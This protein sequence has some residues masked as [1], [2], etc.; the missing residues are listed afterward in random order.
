METD[1]DSQ[2]F[3]KSAGPTAGPTAEICKI[4]S[5]ANIESE[6]YSLFS[7]NNNINNKRKL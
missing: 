4:R 1:N 6:V 2:L 5:T 7:Y 3:D